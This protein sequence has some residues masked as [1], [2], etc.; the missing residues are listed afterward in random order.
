MPAQSDGAR[1]PRINRWSRMI[2]G[3]AAALLAVP[4]VAMRFTSEVNWDAAD[5]IVMGALL[6]AAC[7]AYEIA[8]RLSASMVYRAAAGVAVLGAFLLV[9]VNLAV[10]IV[11]SED[12]PANL[13]FFGVPVVGLV[14]AAL[15]RGRPSGMARTLLAMAAAQVL[16]AVI[17]TVP[18]WGEPVHAPPAV[19]G[20]TLF[21]LAPWLVSAALFRRAARA[22]DLR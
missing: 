19:A 22:S 6:G 9:W 16:V 20:V 21:F 12:N 15:V 11:G 1:A 8:T 18:G 17:A 4:F 2:W 10:G 3:A 14:G 7:G 5:F 13:M